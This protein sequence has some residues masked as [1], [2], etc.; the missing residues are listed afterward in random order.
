MNL[1][2]IGGLL[3][4]GIAA[5]VG[6]VLLGLG[7]QRATTARSTQPPQPTLP[8]RSEPVTRSE[9]APQ[10]YGAQTVRLRPNVPTMGEDTLAHKGE[11][12]RLPALN[13]Q[14]RE[15]AGEI[16]SLHQQAWQL[17]QRLSVLTEMVDH[18]EHT[19]SGHT[20]IEE[21]SYTSPDNTLA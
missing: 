10:R 3:V 17:E 1:L 4:V 20:N 6:A 16:R 11:E 2:I 8:V 12:E 13:G 18:L 7:E 9:P 14:F 21:E 5:I 19:Q 15:L